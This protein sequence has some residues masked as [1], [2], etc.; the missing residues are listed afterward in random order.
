VSAD[1]APF[2]IVHGDQDGVV[3]P[4]QSQALAAALRDAGA[5]VTLHIVLGAGHGVGLPD[6]APLVAEAKAFLDRTLK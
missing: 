6:D 1:S 2:L 3:P 5:N 4:R